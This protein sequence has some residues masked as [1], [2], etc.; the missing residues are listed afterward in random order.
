MPNRLLEQGLQ[1]HRNGR[2]NEAK[3][4]YEQVLAQNPRDPDGLHLLGLTHL[5]T[6]DPGGAVELIRRAV[7]LQPD[8]AAFQSN[9]GEAL[10]AF[11]RPREALA[12]FQRAGKLAP[13][14]PQYQMAIG[15][16]H[17]RCGELVEAEKRLRKLTARFPAYA[18][19][20]L[21]LGNAMRDQQRAQDAL[22]CYERAIA[23]DSDLA[24][25]HNNL[26]SVLHGLG[27]L[28]AAEAAYRRALAIA[29]DHALVQCN[30]VSVLIDRGLFTAA[31]S[32]CHQIIAHAPDLAMAHSFL[33]A[34][35]GHQGRL[36]EALG[37]Y[38]RAATLDPDN[39]LTMAAI[40]ATLHETG[41]TEQAMRWLRE[42]DARAPHTVAVQ[43]LMYSILL[44]QGHWDEG[45][46]RYADREARQLFVRKYSSLKLQTTFD[47]EVAGKTVVLQ[48]EQG[49]GDE[50]F[51]LRF[52]PVLARLGARILYR[53]GSKI[54]SL[55]R[56][57]PA[58]AE[59]T[60][61][62]APVPLGAQVLLAGDLPN[63]LRQLS[64][65]ESASNNAQNLQPKVAPAT[66]L[67]AAGDTADPLPPPLRLSPLADSLE[68][69]RQR[70][71]AA[72][73]PPY[74]GVTWRAGT[75]P[76]LQQATWVLNKEIEIAH[77][78]QAFKGLSGTFIALQRKP[79]PGELDLLSAAIGRPVHD[80]CD[81]NETLE[82]MLALL[83]LI[84]EYVGVSNTN[85]HLRAGVGKN[86]RVLVPQPAEWRWLVTGDHSPWFPD[87]LIYRQGTNGDWRPAMTRLAADLR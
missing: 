20:W 52:A 47:G 24:D 61:E 50:I 10:V 28:E 25:A 39:L 30:L 62:D 17:A 12:A 82:D 41:E 60:A 9:L 8:N 14:E 80:F 37:C 45:W 59:V 63:A 75:P 2:I 23:L 71:A 19:G 26:G 68:R 53:S 38:Q 81:L 87:F 56:R 76:A 70:L 4:I 58:L 40:G 78:G 73:P 49:L 3:N 67:H 74:F 6:D 83:A 16:C 77:L 79:G 43:Q 86:A 34:A 65:R 1:H 64:K 21:N 54:A 66:T 29:P 42:A 15:N 55:L 11:G 18:L 36:Q 69:V 32:V 7:K 48:R 27:Q 33:G 51:F 35:V 85:M 22:A 84:D 72:G 13:N 5:Q 44:A 46:R 31:E 57:V